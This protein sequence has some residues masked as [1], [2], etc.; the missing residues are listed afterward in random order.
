MGMGRSL[1]VFGLAFCAWLLIVVTQVRILAVVPNSLP[2]LQVHPLPPTLAKW[3]VSADIGDY[4]DKVQPPEFGQLVWSQFPI[5]VYVQ[6]A[7]NGSGDRHW[8]QGILG[9]VEEWGVYLPLQVVKAA[10]VADIQ[11]LHEAPPMRQGQLRAR[12]GETRYE[13]YVRQ[14]GSEATLCHRCTVWLNPTQ[15]GKYGPAVARHELGHA[16][17]IWGHSPVETD[18]MYFAQVRNP[19]PISARDVNTLKRVYEEPTRLGWQVVG[20]W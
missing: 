9:V 12:S 18:V 5:K 3:E 8:V 11:I 7:G 20:N 17:G 2:P 4:F 1:S 14:R 16:L 6:S 15:V 10:E 19:P 13:L